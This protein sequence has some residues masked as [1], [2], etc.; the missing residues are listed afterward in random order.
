MSQAPGNAPWAPACVVGVGAQPRVAGLGRALE[1]VDSVQPYWLEPRGP[2]AAYP[3]VSSVGWEKRVG[4]WS[5]VPSLALGSP[6]ASGCVF[7]TGGRAAGPPK[8][9]RCGVL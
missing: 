8:Q 4:S 2:V 6:K 7:L 9:Q 5:L 3:L 1:A